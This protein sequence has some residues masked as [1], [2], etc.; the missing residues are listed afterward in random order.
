[1]RS[2]ET[3]LPPPAAEAVTGQVE[4]VTFH[5]DES[6]FAVLK[7][8]VKGRRD[9]CTVVG[10]VPAVSAGEWLSA[11]GKWNVDPRHGPQFKADQIRTSAPDNAEGIERYLASGLIKGIGPAFAA[12][13]VKKFGKDVFTVIAEKPG[14]LREV[15]GIGRSRERAIT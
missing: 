2:P 4:R 8:S 9:L 5:S 6:G 12:R 7:V 14:R 11:T 3:S 15:E 13:L 1:M 10:T